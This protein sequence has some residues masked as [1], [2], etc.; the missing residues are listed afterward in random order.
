MFK[1][2]IKILFK[3]NGNVKV[4]IANAAHCSHP[5]EPPSPP[6]TLQSWTRNEP[7]QGTKSSKNKWQMSFLGV[8]IKLN[9]TQKFLP[10]FAT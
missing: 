8:A 7:H 4:K 5:K 6:S 10:I 2:W 9:K 1:I 3:D